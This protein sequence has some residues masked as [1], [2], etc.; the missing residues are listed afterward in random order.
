MKSR[1]PA[2]EPYEITQF[3]AEVGMRVRVMRL[4]RGLTQAELAERA[5]I[6]RQT[7]MAIEAGTLASRFVDVAR[8]LWALDDTS[9]QSALATA[10]QDSAFQE[11]ARS[12]LSRIGS[13]RKKAVP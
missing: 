13:R 5:D 1:D 12:G 7:L 2:S 3:V 10:A 4:A 9:L 8:L 6:S 11:A